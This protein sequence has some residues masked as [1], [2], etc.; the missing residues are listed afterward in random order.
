MCSGAC[1]G[2]RTYVGA[3]GCFKDG[4]LSG[5]SGCQDEQDPE[6]RGSFLK[7]LFSF[8]YRCGYGCVQRGLPHR[9][10]EGVGFTGT[11]AT[12]GL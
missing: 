8:M 12:G 4:E 1:L 3:S 11:G 6:T 10:V 9:S 5:E 7:G 2:F